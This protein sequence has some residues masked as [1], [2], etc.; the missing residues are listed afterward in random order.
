MVDS[1]IV[2][3]FGER[4][5]LVIM[6]GKAV[7]GVFMHACDVCGSISRSSLTFHNLAW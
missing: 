7:S 1:G 6:N 2:V 3:G 4:E 5:R